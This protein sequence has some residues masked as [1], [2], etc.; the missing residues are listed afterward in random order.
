M[1][2][3][4][5]ENLSIKSN[6]IAFNEFRGYAYPCMWTIKQLEVSAEDL[7]VLQNGAFLYLCFFFFILVFSGNFS[8]VVETSDASS[9]HLGLFIAIN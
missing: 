4:E 5:T 9:S 6:K 3:G 1:K 7:I 8:H 2:V